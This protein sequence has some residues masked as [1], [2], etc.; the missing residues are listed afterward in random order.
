MAAAQTHRTKL[1]HTP[2]VVMG[3][4]PLKQVRCFAPFALLLTAKP[5]ADNLC[6][7]VYTEVF[8]AGHLAGN[9]NLVFLCQNLRLVICE[10]DI[11][12][13]YFSPIKQVFCH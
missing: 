10:I 13:N 6:A 3:S 2:P 1:D 4:K 5:G 11:C 8:L 9:I 12:Q 7:G